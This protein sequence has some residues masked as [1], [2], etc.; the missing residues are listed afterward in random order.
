MELKTK[1]NLGFTIVFLIGVWL[2]FLAANSKSGGLLL[3]AFVM[4]AAGVIYFFT[5]TDAGANMLGTFEE[6]KRDARQRRRRTFLNSR[7]Q[8]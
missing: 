1:F 3:A 7:I 8:C 4:V 5:A 6:A 2:I